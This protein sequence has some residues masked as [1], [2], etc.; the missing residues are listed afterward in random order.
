[1]PRLCSSRDA[2]LRRAWSARLPFNVALGPYD[3]TVGFRERSRMAD[4][5]RLACVN[6]ADRRIELRQDLDGLRLAEVFLDSVIR[7]S[8]F[9]K[10]CQQGCVE[11]AYTHSLATGL[12]EF[13]QRN[14]R[15]W[16]WF[17]LLLAEHVPGRPRYDRVVRGAVARPPTMPR[18]VLVGGEPVALRS[19]SKAETGS[20]FGWYHF[21]LREAQLFH[22]LTG[23]N[24]AVVALHEI[25]HAVHHRYGIGTGD[26][27]RDFKEAQLKGWFGI[28]TG[29]PDA[30]R[31]L[32]WL[33][34]FPERARLRAPGRALRRAA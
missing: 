31:W 16:R 30:W 15:A 23:S 2:P 1:M 8:H 27:H 33:M 5:R 9:S 11:E 24:L 28:M 26:S 20:A 14:E 18:R 34:S 3:L 6:L 25:T 21:D 17:N 29:C 4:R 7:L 22:G 13:A 12:V 32:A 19:I 10:G